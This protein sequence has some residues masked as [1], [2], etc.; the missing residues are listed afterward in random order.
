MINYTS[1]IMN[2]SQND[3]FGNKESGASSKTS[4]IIICVLNAPLMLI[5]IIGNSLVWPPY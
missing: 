4:A 5:S 2:A 3:D 1:V